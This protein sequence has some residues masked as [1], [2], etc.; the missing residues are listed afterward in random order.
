MVRRYRAVHGGIEEADQ[1][2]LVY[3][4]DYAALESSAAALARENDA[5]TKAL[6]DAAAVLEE[7]R[8]ILIRK[9]DE[10]ERKAFWKAVSGRE[11]ARAALNP[12]TASKETSD[13]G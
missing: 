12:T 5:L 9:L 1:G 13:A 6:S 4:D 10:P 2:G 3:H 8:L 7:I 11:A